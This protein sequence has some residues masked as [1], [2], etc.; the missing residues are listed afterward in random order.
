[1]YI[2]LY[3]C[4]YINAGYYMVL[5]QE[6]RALRAQA[7]PRRVAPGIPCDVRTLYNVHRYVPASSAA[8]MTRGR[9]Y[10]E[11]LTRRRG[12]SRCLASSSFLATAY[13]CTHATTSV[14]R[15]FVG[16][17]WG[18]DLGPSFPHNTLSDAHRCS[19]TAG[20]GAL[21]KCCTTRCG[22]AQPTK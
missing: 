12:E 20:T 5:V 3:N 21:V 16:Q 10:L 1:M 2:Y 7:V 15:V 18:R 11:R 13:T 19:H 6:L 14:S 8:C 22:D 4:M 9:A 17:I